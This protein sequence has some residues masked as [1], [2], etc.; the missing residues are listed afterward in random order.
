VVKSTAPTE[1]TAVNIT[2]NILNTENNPNAG[3]NL[4]TCNKSKTDDNLNP[5][6]TLK[7]FIKYLINLNDFI[8]QP[9][10]TE[11]FNGKRIRKMV[12]RM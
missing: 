8:P 2:G 6:D 7:C 1:K 12:G 10:P 4:N 3:D 11:F 5:D 9:I